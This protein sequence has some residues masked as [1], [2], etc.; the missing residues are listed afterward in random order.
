[1]RLLLRPHLRRCP[2]CHR[3]SSGGTGNI[4]PVLPPMKER[5]VLRHLG[6]EIRAARAERGLTLSQV[7][8]KAAVSVRSLQDLEAGRRSPTLSTLIAVC[9]ALDLSLWLRKKTPGLEVSRRHPG[10]VRPGELLAYTEKAAS[11]VRQQLDADRRRR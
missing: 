8:R 6:R 9:R 1:M 10:P 5:V 3:R 2:R 11:E 4:L 7:A